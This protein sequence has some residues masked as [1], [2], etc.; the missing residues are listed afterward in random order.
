[1]SA[2]YVGSSSSSLTSSVLS[3][4]GGNTSEGFNVSGSNISGSNISGGGI[5]GILKGGRMSADYVGSSSSSLTSQVLGAVSTAASVGVLNSNTSGT[6]TQV[7]LASRPVASATTTTG[8]SLSTLLIVLVLLV[9]G[10]F[11]YEK[12]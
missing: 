1:M 5:S 11:A 12:L 3:Y 6:Q 9:V 2:D 7:P 4:S 8:S 10:W